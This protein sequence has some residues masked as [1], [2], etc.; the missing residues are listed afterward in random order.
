ML[1]FKQVS[2]SLKIFAF[3]GLASL[4][5]LLAVVFGLGP[6]ALGTALI[7][8]V[9]EIT[10]SFDNAIVNAKILERL[11]PAWQTAFLTIGI[12]LAIFVV[13]LVLPIV[14]V[15]VSASLGF[16]Q[17]VT[18]ALHHPGVYADKLALAHS[19]IASFG[20]AFLLCLA[21]EFFVNGEHEVLW[22][23]PFERRAKQL[24]H[25]LTPLVVV[26]ILVA[27]LALA[28]S[29]L[30]VLV[31]G[32][33]GVASFL[34]IQLMILALGGNH[35]SGK[36]LAGWAGLGLFIYLQI[37]DA[38]FSLDGVVGAFAISDKVLLIAAGLGIGALW[39]RSLTIFIVRRGTLAEYR[40]LEHGA[41]YTILV[42]AISL[43]A[44]LFASIPNFVTGLVGVAIIAGA[45]VS[46]VKARRLAGTK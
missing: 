34:V 8:A 24:A 30:K 37:L 21:L 29:S 1:E 39:V 46:S 22:L 19:V 44:S 42:L 33:V 14:I 26:L 31:A 11:S 5:V 38:S 35:A 28:A 41:Y 16:G 4:A 23:A 20:G 6:A 12:I 10:F 40:Y 15:A 36:Q 43:F 45:V 2:Q 32:A 25:F 17:V 13:R 7:L 18:L 27:I 9:I 3:A